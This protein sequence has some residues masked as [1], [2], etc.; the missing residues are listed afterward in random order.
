[1]YEYKSEVNAYRWLDDAIAE[2]APNEEHLVDIL[3]KERYEHRRNIIAIRQD[4][5]WVE[6]EYLAFIIAK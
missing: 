2:T 5:Y 3:E 6:N 4:S 1:M